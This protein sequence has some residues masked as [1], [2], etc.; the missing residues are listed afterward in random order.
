MQ[1][2]DQFILDVLI[3][4][5]GTG[6]LV[7][8]C[9]CNC[10]KSELIATVCN[11]NTVQSFFYMPVTWE[12]RDRNTY[13]TY[14]FFHPYSSRCAVFGS[15]F[16]VMNCTGLQIAMGYHPPLWNLSHFLLSHLFVNYATSGS[17]KCSCGSGTVIFCPDAFFVTL[18]CHPIMW[19]FSTWW[20]DWGAAILSTDACVC[21]CM[22]WFPQAA[23]WMHPRAK[24]QLWQSFFLHKILNRLVCRCWKTL[25]IVH[26]VLID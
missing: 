5:G 18:S 7:D 14:A 25:W 10:L 12:C 23:L 2:G 26:R 16:S 15:V 19:Q 24:Q 20:C 3:H 9:S 17:A 4:V 1:G 13:H 22:L 6:D 21:S 8:T 11:I